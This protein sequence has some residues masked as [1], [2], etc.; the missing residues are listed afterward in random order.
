MNWLNKTLCAVVAAGALL[1]TGGCLTSTVVPEPV[2]S[3][4][5]SFD[6]T[7][8]NSG[9][10]CFTTNGT[11]ILTPHARDRY[12][13]LIA[14]YGTNFIPSLTNDAGIVPTLTNT[15][16]IDAEHLADFCSMNRWKK[17]GK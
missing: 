8:Q 1:L 12:N 10:I 5:T 16:E 3:T 9:L 17:S 15:Y 14:R 7:N 2:V 11:A 4:A 6:G 13:L